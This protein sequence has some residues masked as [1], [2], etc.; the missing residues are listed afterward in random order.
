MLDLVV[1]LSPY[2]LPVSSTDLD[3]RSSDAIRVR[4]DIPL[5][6]DVVP[7]PVI[8]RVP[9]LGPAIMDTLA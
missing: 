3:G 1:S 6:T 9:I 4:H 2:K 8:G 5:R 7:P